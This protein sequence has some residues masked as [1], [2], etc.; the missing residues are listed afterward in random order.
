M[1]TIIRDK[2]IENR[3]RKV[4]DIKDERFGHLVAIEETPE[5]FLFDFVAHLTNELSANRRSLPIPVD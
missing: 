3:G 2:K 1:P 4:K 5:R